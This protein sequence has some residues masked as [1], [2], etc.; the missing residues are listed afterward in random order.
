MNIKKTIIGLLVLIAAVNSNAQVNEKEN[1]GIGFLVGEP[2]GF[3]FKYWKSKEYAID[4]G[5]AW[6]FLGNDGFQIYS[7][8][9]FHDYR[10]N[11]SE[12]WPAYYG[13]G[14]LLE[15]EKDEGRKNDGDTIFGI[16]VPF[17]MTYFFENKK[18]YEFFIELA[19]VLELAPDIDIS[20][21]VGI[22]LRFYF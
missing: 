10:L 20:A 22:G 3:S 18:P 9:L 16:R 17:G 21:N 5:M 19:P 15:F 13:I 7:D 8:Y 14:A 6:S 1:F 4:G 11:N 12:Q 2:T